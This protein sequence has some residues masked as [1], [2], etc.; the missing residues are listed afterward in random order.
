MT[1]ARTQEPIEEGLAKLGLGDLPSDEIPELALML[2]SSGVESSELAALAGALPIEHPAD[3]RE[4]LHRALRSAGIRVPDRISAAHTLK[5]ILAGR[6]V[7]GSLSARDAAWS[8]ISVFH[9]V[10]LELSP[11]G[12]YVG[13]SFGIA[14]L[15]G[16]YYSYDDVRFDDE[17]A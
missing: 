8:I 15:F 17:A 11:A 12:R 16:L 6:A 13:D 9:E 7:D 2:L 4:D 1:A 14:T 5:R 10:E 3:L